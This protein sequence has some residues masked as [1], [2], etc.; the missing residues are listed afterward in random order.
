MQSQMICAAFSAI[1]HTSVNKDLI[2]YNILIHVWEAD[3]VMFNIGFPEIFYELYNFTNQ[4]IP[5]GENYAI[6][7]YF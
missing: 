5:L 6:I 1:V 3:A 2:I 4:G 7:A